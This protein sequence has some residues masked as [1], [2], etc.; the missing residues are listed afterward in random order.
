VAE[1]LGMTFSLV[2]AVERRARKQLHH[3]LEHAAG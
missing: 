3:A 2:Q 1:Q